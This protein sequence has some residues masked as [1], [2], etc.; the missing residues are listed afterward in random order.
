MNKKNK[1]AVVLT[2][3]GCLALLFCSLL[4]LVK[5]ITFD[6]TQPAQ[7][8]SSGEDSFEQLRSL[9]YVTWTAIDEEEA[10]KRD[11]TQYDPESACE[12]INLYYSINKEGGYFFNMAGDILHTFTDQRA[13]KRKIKW[14]LIEPYLNNEFLILEE[15]TEIFRIDWDS[16]VKAQITGPYHH[17]IAV[18]DD[19][20]FYALMH[21]KMDIPE[22]SATEP[23]LNEWLVHITKDGVVDKKISFVKMFSENQQLFAY[24]KIPNQNP[25]MKMRIE[26]FCPDAWDVFHTNTIEII[27]R[28]IFSS[29]RKL[30][31]KG[32]ILFCNRNQNLIGAIDVLAEKI[33]WYWGINHLDFPHTPSL[34]ENG[35]ILVFDNGYHR[36]YSRI[37]EF[38]PASGETEWEYKDVPPTSFLSAEMGSVQRL[39]N[40]NTL[41]TESEHGRV[42][43]ITRDGDVVWEFYNP[44]IK[45]TFNAE[46]AAVEKK[47]ASIYRMNRFTDPQKYPFIKNLK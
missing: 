23:I 47:R 5:Y 12:G 21:A 31:G 45:K 24:A 19:G 2:W 39:D 41:I 11:V 30:F 13:I 34:L 8:S 26:D 37:I 38:N 16:N 20:G 14:R 4:Y 40:G 29:G 35:N 6:N 10:K 3:I 27:D 36:K 15:N 25:D 33:I 46:L 43:E 32:D 44:Q 1:L 9:G 22:F 7:T 42:F 28:D 17:D 18:D